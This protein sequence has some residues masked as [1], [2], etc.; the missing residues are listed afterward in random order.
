MSLPLDRCVRSFCERNMAENEFE[1][2]E[3]AKKSRKNKR[4]AQR[5]DLVDA[6]REP[7]SGRHSN[8]HGPPE[9][10][11]LA[12][13][14][15][16][17]EKEE[18]KRHTDTSADVGLSVLLWVGRVSRPL[19][20]E[21]DDLTGDEGRHQL[22]RVADDFEE[23]SRP[24]EESDAL[25]QTP[26]EGCLLLAI[27]DP[28]LLLLVQPLALGE[29]P[30]G[31]FEDRGLDGSGGESCVILVCL[32]TASSEGQQESLGG[33][34]RLSGGIELPETVDLSRDKNRCK[35]RRRAVNREKQGERTR[36]PAGSVDSPGSSW[37]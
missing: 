29:G 17:G 1:G 36:W 18:S 22:G 25:I 2:K 8:R 24:K 19:L 32:G 26:S 37:A 3:L 34:C 5:T 9:E 27:L 30:L 21:E 33:R 13:A 28:P 20:S 16:N 4:I 10:L 31:A 12:H 23:T 11:V 35:F 6:S 7:R 15:H 14:R